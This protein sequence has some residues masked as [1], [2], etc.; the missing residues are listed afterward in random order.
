ME[1]ERMF[2]PGAPDNNGTLAR[3][4]AQAGSGAHTTIDKV[5]DAARPAVDRIASGAHQAVDKMTDVAHQTA[6]S[7]GLKGE[8]IKDAQVRL[9]NGLSEYVHANPLASLGI[10]VATGFLLSRLISSK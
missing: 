10:A 5:S 7:L 8:Q 4:I 9:V 2:A 1:N 6:D 3:G